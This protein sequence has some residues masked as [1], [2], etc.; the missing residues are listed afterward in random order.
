MMSLLKN[1]DGQTLRALAVALR[2]GRLGAPFTPAALQRYCPADGATAVAGQLQRLAEEGLRPE[3]LAL[4][5]EAVAQERAAQIIASDAVDLVWSG[6]E[7]AETINRDTGVVVRELFSSARQSVMVAG[8][9]VYQGRE[10]FHALAERMEAFPQLQVLMFLDVQRHHSDTSMDSEILARF[11]QRFRTKE[12]PGS[13]LPQVFYDPRS[14]AMEPKQ[15][16]SMHAKCI[17]IDQQV[18]LVTSANF[19]QA[20]QVRNIEVGLLIRSER[21]STQLAKHFKA[22]VETGL[23]LPIL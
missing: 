13:R 4:M 23:L 15:R 22:L 14:L 19:T 8:F 11:V 2:S 21:I 9:A 1:M 6:P 7:A 17:V 16:S 12:W 10:V 3:H 5:L 18:A 20:A